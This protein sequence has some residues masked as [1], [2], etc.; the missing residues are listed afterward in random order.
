MIEHMKRKDV[1]NPGRAAEDALAAKERMTLN[2]AQLVLDIELVD[3]E[4]LATEGVMR[5]VLH[6]VEVD[7]SRR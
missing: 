7:Q 1:I 2:L 3:S 5:V 6:V 4:L